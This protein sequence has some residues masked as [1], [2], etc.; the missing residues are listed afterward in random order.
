MQRSLQSAMTTVMWSL[1]LALALTSVR[2]FLVPP[3]V[4][5]PVEILALSRHHLLLL[6]HIAAG[7]VAISVGPFQF[8]GALRDARPALHRA[9]GYAYLTAVLLAGCVGL[10]LS[11]DTAIFAADGLN[12]LTAI[13]LSFLGL[14][15]AFLGYSA[16][17]KFSPTQFFLVE[18]GFAVLAIVWL[19]TTALAF[20]RARQRRFID[21]RAWMIRSYSLSFA[22]ATVRLVGLPILV[23]T[24]NPVVAVT[25]TFW[26][27]LLNLMVA[28][29]MTLRSSKSGSPRMT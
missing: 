7:I 4:L 22:A 23:L 17:S 2:F 9:M 13:D 5:L 25:C 12:A 28:E 18:V 20:V 29:W 14:S 26:S 24:R 15:P 27:W 19:T 21:H 1:A 3:P 6:L 10:L 11:S 16:S 8:V